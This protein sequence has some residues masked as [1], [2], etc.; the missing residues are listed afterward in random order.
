MQ[1]RSSAFGADGWGA[2]CKSFPVYQVFYT[3]FPSSFANLR[4][5]GR[6]E[7]LFARFLSP[8]TIKKCF[9]CALSEL[10]LQRTSDGNRRKYPA[11]ALT[12]AG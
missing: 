1:D 9:S 7:K 12:F 4:F 5:F 10:E 6:I 11:K 2:L 3:C 8:A